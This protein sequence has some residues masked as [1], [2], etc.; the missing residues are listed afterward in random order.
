MNATP[1]RFQVVCTTALLVLVAAVPLQSVKGSVI[2]AAFH[3]EVGASILLLLSALLGVR[4]LGRLYATVLACALWLLLQASMGGSLSAGMQLILPVA[5]MVVVQPSWIYVRRAMLIAGVTCA[6]ICLAES[7]LRSNFYSEWFGTSVR[8]P[9]ATFR[10]SGLLGHPLVSSIQIALG[11]AVAGR[12]VGHRWVGKLMLLVLLFAGAVSTGS[13]SGMILVALFGLY[14]FRADLT[15][16]TASMRLRRRLLAFVA[17]MAI[18]PAF[19]FSTTGFESTSVLNSIGREQ[20]SDLS[21]QVRHDGLVFA[22]AAFPSRPIGHILVGGGLGSLGQLVRASGAVRSFSSVDDA[23]VTGLFDLGII[24]W[25]LLVWAI[26][27]R[28]RRQTRAFSTARDVQSQV[29][30]LLGTFLV[31]SLLFDTIYWSYTSVLFAAV[32][33][34]SRGSAVRRRTRSNAS[35]A[36]PRFTGSAFLTDG[37]AQ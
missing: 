10:S 27:V 26:A 17:I 32:I 6:T 7:L 22:A 9:S 4:S 24:P 2:T 11:A 28:V 37:V 35:N 19:Y 14:A 1:H 16:R 23:F 13:V 33:C 29:G 30:L 20:E 31:A 18:V 15:W 3:L 36:T 21:W 34:C 12:I 8:L 5:A 25:A